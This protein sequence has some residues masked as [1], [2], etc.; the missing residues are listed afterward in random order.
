M[1]LSFQYTDLSTSVRPCTGSDKG[2]GP[3]SNSEASR[4]PELTLFSQLPKVSRPTLSGD[5]PKMAGWTGLEPAT[6][7]VTG[8]LTNQKIV[9]YKS[10]KR[11]LDKSAL[12]RNPLKTHLVGFGASRGD[13]GV[14]LSCNA[15]NHFNSLASCGG[16]MARINVDVRA[17]LSDDRWFPLLFEIKDQDRAL[18]MLCRFWDRGQDFW[19]LGETPIPNDRFPS[20]W[21]VLVKTNWG[22][23]VE[24]GVYVKGSRERFAWIL[25]KR[26]AGRMGGKQTQANASTLKQ[27]QPSYS[28][29]SS[30]ISN[31]E[32]KSAKALPRAEKIQLSADGVWN[33]VT[34]EIK[35]LWKKAYPAVDIPV[36]LQ[37]AAAWLVANPKNKKKNYSRFINSWLCRSQDRA[38]RVQTQTKRIETCVKCNKEPLA[39]GINTQ[40][41]FVCMDCY[42]NPRKAASA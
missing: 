27:N 22:E 25:S 39:G 8:R 23:R 32:E 36:E 31:S 37:K 18:G 11:E 6:S 15:P 7:C 14:L 40:G 16:L 28:S 2:F 19:K 4:T 38:P 34:S 30:L 1:L 35:E 42:Y 10:F 26:E 17:V 29:S 3:F 12:R 5:A 33:N 20:D 13:G 21:E 41:G 9:A 24:G